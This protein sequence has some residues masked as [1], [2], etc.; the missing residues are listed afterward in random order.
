ML[1]YKIYVS[2]SIVTDIDTV[3]TA[4]FYHGRDTQSKKGI[5]SC[6]SLPHSPPA[7]FWFTTQNGG[8][9]SAELW[10]AACV[11]KLEMRASARQRPAALRSPP[12]SW[13][14]CLCPRVP[15]AE[16][17]PSAGTGAQLGKLRHSCLG[18]SAGVA[19][20]ELSPP[21]CSKSFFF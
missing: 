16:P 17:G 18:S 1:L 21:A 4:S 7:S 20:S 3:P 6:Q 5:S 8:T 10:T 15:P 13:W 19:L 9:W 2:P 12:R 11:W 14:R